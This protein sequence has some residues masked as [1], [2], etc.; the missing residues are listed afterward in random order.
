MFLLS[1]VRHCDSACSLLYTRRMRSWSQ[2]ERPRAAHDFPVNRPD[3]AGVQRAFIRIQHLL[4]DFLLTGR[5]KHLVAVIV[6]QAADLGGQGGSL[7]DELEDMQV[8]L[9]DMASE[10]AERR[11]HSVGGGGTVAA[12][13]LARHNGSRPWG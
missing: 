2:L 5:G 7:V 6:F 12:L 11:S 1:Q 10:T 9:V 3:G 13:G 8:Q 4:Q